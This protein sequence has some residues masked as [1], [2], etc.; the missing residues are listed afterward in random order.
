MVVVLGR[1]L[2]GQEEAVGLGLLVVVAT[3]VD[4]RAGTQER[5]KNALLLCCTYVNGKGCERT[6]P[7][8]AHA[9]ASSSSSVGSGS[10][11]ASLT[12]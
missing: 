5:R 3:V 12:W 7:S 4:G 1:R 2:E 10:Q 9:V 8:H 11:E 6:R